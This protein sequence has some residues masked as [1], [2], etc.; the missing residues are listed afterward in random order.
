MRTTVTLDADVAALVRRHMRE[1]NATFKEVVNEALLAAL[2]T[3][4]AATTFSTPTFDTGGARV[5]LERALA[6]AG[7]LEDEAIL[8]KRRVGS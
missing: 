6:L 1:R 7:D 3:E 4:G 8:R 2:R 5:P